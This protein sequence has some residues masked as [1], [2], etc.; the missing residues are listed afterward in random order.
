MHLKKWLCCH[1]VGSLSW[2]LQIS[3][4]CP[5]DARNFLEVELLMATGMIMQLPCQQKRIVSAMA[6]AVI[7]MYGYD[8]LLPLPKLVHYGLAGAAVDLTC[9][10]PDAARGGQ[11]MMYSAGYGIAGAMAYGL[12]M[13]RGLSY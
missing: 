1:A 9:R 4:H 12:L 3:H 11:E 10:G 5:L 13:G 8:T 6:G 7:S 2:R